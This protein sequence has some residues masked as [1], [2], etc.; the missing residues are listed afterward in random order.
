MSVPDRFG[1]NN[2]SWTVFTLVETT[3]FIDSDLARQAGS[4]SKHLKLR[5]QFAFAV[6]SAGWAGSAFRADI[7]TDEYM[8]FKGC[9]SGISSSI[10]STGCR[11]TAY[12]EAQ[13]G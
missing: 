2:N 3:G 5:E 13:D 7:L 8:T 6:A 9:Q 10:Y 12:H 1:I 4:F 11:R